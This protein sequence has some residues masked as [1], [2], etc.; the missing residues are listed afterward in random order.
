MDRK[1]FT[2]TITDDMEELTSFFSTKEMKEG[3]EDE[4]KEKKM[5]SRARLQE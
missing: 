2:K 4:K 5:E 1:G 3:M